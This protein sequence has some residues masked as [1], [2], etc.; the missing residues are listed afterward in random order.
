VT[1]DLPGYDGPS[2]ASLADTVD[3]RGSTVRTV[4]APFTGDAVGEVPDCTAGDMERAVERA[5]RAG[6]SWASR[7]TAARV[8]AVERFRSLVR[9]HRE[10]LLDVVQ[11]E[12]GK[13]RHDALEEVLDVELTAGHYAEKAPEYLAVEKRKGLIPVL[14]RVRHHRDPRGVAGFITPWNYPLTLAVSDCLPALLAGNSV[15]IKPAEATP[16]TALFVARLLRE[17][18]VPDDCVQVVPG[19][20]KRL[21]PPLIE[22]VD[23]VTFTGSTAT[24]RD[25]AA[26]AGR[27]LV[28]ASLELGGKGPMVVRE[29]API[30]R[31]VTGAV[32]GA[33]A[34]AGQ[35]C[36]AVERIY[37]HESVAPAFRDRL[38]SRTR[39]LELG[40]G[41]DYGPDVGSLVSERQLERVESHVEE[42]VE[43]GATLLTGGRRR[44]DVGP[45]VYEPTVLS[46]VPDGTPLAREETFGPVV[47]VEPVPDEEAALTRANDTDYG[48]HG[49][50]WTG[51]TASGRRL[52]RRLDC[53][54]VAVNDAYVAT[55]AS[56][57][58]PMG[59]MKDSGVGR[60][61]GDEGFEKYTQSQSVVVQHGHPLAVPSRVPNA[62]AARGLSGLLWIARRLGVR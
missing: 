19:D 59:G 21:G 15:V 12:S 38:V 35:L 23:H 22:G 34:S 58:A 39:E 6:E 52:A 45:Y 9:T 28:P 48:L 62:L 55:W 13:A 41:F 60:R 49:S 47:T 1:T 27:E 17:A 53:G 51:D 8:A 32:R 40:T 44:P 42:A 10:E 54:T 29:D 24:G 46:D 5:R 2:L 20:G 56:T 30:G 31:T 50:V 37:V 33:F 26:R 3:S 36:I 11:L 57:D 7:P 16:H 14:T 61:H 4:T 43:A 18:G 25:V